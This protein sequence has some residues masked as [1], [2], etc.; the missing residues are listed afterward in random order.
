M[1][2]GL[3]GLGLDKRTFWRLD[4]HDLERLTGQVKL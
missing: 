3:V 4:I 1:I 2:R